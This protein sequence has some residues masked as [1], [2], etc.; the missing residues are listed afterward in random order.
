[1][2]DFIKNFSQGFYD[3]C[4]NKQNVTYQEVEDVFMKLIPSLVKK[5]ILVLIA[6]I[7]TIPF[8]FTFK[9]SNKINFL[10]LEFLLWIVWI[11]STLDLDEF[12]QM[13]AKINSK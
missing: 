9:V 8:L 3:S 11:S 5:L 4:P 13:K 1:M 10:I 7:V 6:M 12:R 2:K